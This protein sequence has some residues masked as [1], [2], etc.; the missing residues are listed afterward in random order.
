MLLVDIACIIHELSHI[1]ISLLTLTSIDKLYYSYNRGRVFL[2]VLCR[3]NSSIWRCFS[4]FLVGIAP[5][6]FILTIVLV[7]IITLNPYVIGFLIYMLFYIKYFWISKEDDNCAGS[8]LKYLIYRKKYT[9]KEID[10]MIKSGYMA[11][12]CRLLKGVP[13][14]I[15]RKSPYLG[16]EEKES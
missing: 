16:E 6:L 7:S 3:G 9:K 12:D 15:F 5:I 1:V 2:A 4:I 10:K 8:Y 13:C 11:V 14:L